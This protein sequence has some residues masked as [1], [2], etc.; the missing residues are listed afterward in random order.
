MVRTAVAGG[1]SAWAGAGAGACGVSGSS[2]AGREE[3]KTA[4]QWVLRLV[5]GLAKPTSRSDLGD[6]LESCRGTGVGVLDEST[7]RD[8]P[9][10]HLPH[11]LTRPSTRELLGP[12]CLGT[13]CAYAGARGKGRR[14]QGSA[15]PRSRACAPTQYTALRVVEIDHGSKVGH[16][17]NPTSLPPTSPRMVVC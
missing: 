16:I 15:D 3:R 7:Y 1:C 10:R 6:P 13:H 4:G 12:G 2:P 17:T 8:L 11:C 5:A 9:P 14:L